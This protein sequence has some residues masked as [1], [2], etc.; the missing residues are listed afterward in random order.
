MAPI[1]FNGIALLPHT[2]LCA[3]VFLPGSGSLLYI[4]QIFKSLFSAKWKFYK[5]KASMDLKFITERVIT[6]LVCS[7]G[8]PV[9]FYRRLRGKCFLGRGVF[10]RC[11]TKS[12]PEKNWKQGGFPGGLVQLQ[13]NTTNN[14]LNKKSPFLSIWLDIRKPQDFMCQRRSNR[15]KTQ[16]PSTT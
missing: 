7:S 2:T 5:Y 3:V 16:T 1:H 10:F 14:F 8:C 12:G 15:D 9:K 4:V 6:D 11:N 13:I